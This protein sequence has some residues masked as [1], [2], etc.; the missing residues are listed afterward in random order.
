[1]RPFDIIVYGATGYTG[2]RV[3]RYL[4]KSHPD[5]KVAIAGRSLE[6]LTQLAEE[7]NLPDDHILVA[8]I[9]EPSK[10]QE[11]LSQ[12]KMV[13][14]CAGPYRHVGREIV[15]AAIK[16]K[17]DYLDL[18]GEPQFFN[19][20][21][22]EFDME[23]RESNTLVIS[24]CAFDCVPAEL[25]AKLATREFRNKYGDANND[26]GVVTNLEIIH[27]FD[28]V[29]GGNPTT[30]HAAVDGFHAS[31]TGEL[32]KSRANVHKTLNI[33]KPPKPPS[34]WPH[35]AI[36]P[37][38]KP[39]YHEGTDT[40]LLK[41]VGADAACILAT[42]RYLRHRSGDV[43]QYATYKDQ[44][45]PRLTLSFGVPSSSIA[46]K[47]LSYGGIFSFL[48]RY[49]WGCDM[50]HGNPELFSN[51][52]FRKGGPTDEELAR[53]SFKTYCNAYGMTKDQ[54]V[55][56]TCEGPEPGYIATPKMIVALAMTIL[57]HRDSLPFGGGVMVPGAAFGDCEEV[58]TSLKHE[59]I[60]FEVQN[61]GD[62]D[63]KV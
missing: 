4:I 2:K 49:K 54:V 62:A 52:L 48:A 5:T 12:G 38:V 16:A 53:G 60:A 41:F 51:G 3:A 57:H 1:M 26:G 28:G 56:V 42:D 44:P 15:Q 13:L 31:I 37:N 63:E 9:N 24:A 11:I 25:S 10:L 36:S 58:Y 55:T 32:K 6:K 40:H 23:A 22:A 19:D 34:S 39:I 14:A 7:L 21:L 47:F 20:T 46:Y 8:G 33:P 61:N 35:L 43:E 30:F 50:L 27:T 29:A 17:T 59:G 18:C 45:H